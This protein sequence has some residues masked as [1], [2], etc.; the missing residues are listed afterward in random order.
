MIKN[1]ILLIDDDSL[2]LKTFTRFLEKQD[3]VVIPAD[4]YDAAMKAI[5]EEEFNLILSDI[6][7]PG[8]NGVGSESAAALFVSHSQAL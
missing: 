1:R 4:S 3:Y 5:K 6:R 2:V 8:K 7:M